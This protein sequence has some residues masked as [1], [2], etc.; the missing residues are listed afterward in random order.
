MTDQSRQ[1]KIQQFNEFFSIKK[2][3]SINIKVLP[4]DATPLSYEAFLAAMPLPFKMATDISS[5]D[6]SALRALQGLSQVASQLVDFLNLQSQKIDMLVSYILSQQQDQTTHYDGIEFGGGGIIFT[7]AQTMTCDTFIEL[8]IFILS[9]N[10]ALFCIGEIIEIEHTEQG[11][12][13]K[14]IFHHIREEDR[15]IL[16]RTSLHEQAKQLQALAKQRNPKPQ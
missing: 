15:E 9:A 2:D 13:H 11:Y 10:C 8:K 1:Q 7:S 12:Q 5:I 4:K 3:F 14:V 16:V 6:H